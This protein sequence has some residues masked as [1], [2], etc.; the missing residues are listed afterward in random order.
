MP[1]FMRSIR[2][3]SFGGAAFKLHDLPP[4]P[5]ND[6]MYAN[7]ADQNRVADL[8]NLLFEK[9]DA[10]KFDELS[11]SY[12][13]AVCAPTHASAGAF[14]SPHS[15]AHGE[16]ECDFENNVRNVTER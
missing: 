6:P 4:Y 15:A 1:T 3:L 5:I 13:Y 12:W 10:I 8:V 11:W 9:F 14:R 16:F 2:A 7:V